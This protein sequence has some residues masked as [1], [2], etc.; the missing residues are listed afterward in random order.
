MSCIALGVSRARA[1]RAVISLL[2]LGSLPVACGG[3]NGGAPGGRITVDVGVLPITDM[4]PLFLGMRK[5]FFAKEDLKVEPHF[6]E[7][8]AVVVPAV[9]SGEFEFG[10]PAATS[11]VIAVSKGLPLRIVTR[12]TRGGSRRAESWTGVLVRADGP[13]RNAEDLEGKTISVPALVGI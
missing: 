8:G 2:I 7:A 13:I 10:W 9:V 1:A 6:A 12:G 5:G 11:L 4:A 3:E